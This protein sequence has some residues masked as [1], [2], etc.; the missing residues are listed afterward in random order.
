MKQSFEKETKVLFSTNVFETM[1]YAQKYFIQTF[2]FN[3]FSCCNIRKY[4][5]EMVIED[6]VTGKK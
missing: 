2:C 5:Q 6:R 3:P 4:A 1:K